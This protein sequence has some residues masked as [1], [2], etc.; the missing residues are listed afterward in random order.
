MSNYFLKKEDYAFKQAIFFGMGLSHLGEVKKQVQWRHRWVHVVLG[1][2]ECL[3]VVG[4]IVSLIELGIISFFKPSVRCRFQQMSDVKKVD[5]VARKMPVSFSCDLSKNHPKVSLPLPQSPSVDVSLNFPSPSIDSLKRE[6]TGFIWPVDLDH[7]GL[8]REEK[9]TIDLYLKAGVRDA[10][11]TIIGNKICFKNGKIVVLNKKIALLNSQNSSGSLRFILYSGKLFCL[12][13]SRKLEPVYDFSLGKYFLKKNIEGPLEKEL[14]VH[15]QENRKKRG[16]STELFFEEEEHVL[17]SLRSQNL[18]QFLN[19]SPSLSLQSKILLFKDLIEEMNW[20]HKKRIQNVSLE[21]GGEII[22]DYFAFHNNIHFEHILIST[23]KGEWRA[24]FC[25]WGEAAAHPLNFVFSPVF[26]SPEYQNFYHTVSEEDFSNQK[27]NE[28]VAFNL[29]HGQ[30]KDFWA[31]GWIFLSIL[32]GKTKKIEGWSSE[33]SK[34][35]DFYI[36]PVDCLSFFENEILSQEF[37]DERLNEI[38][39]GLKK[40]SEEKEKIEGLFQ[41]I[42]SML[43]LLP[44]ERKIPSVNDLEIFE[45]EENRSN[46]SENSPEFLDES[47]P[48]IEQW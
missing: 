11:F 17:E 28:I 14:L 12:N 46:S 21:K 42:S 30:K 15:M 5:S 44:E 6:E 2:T 13:N 38:K 43:K 3:P 1:L 36:P 31:L 47:H 16:L 23:E 40:E 34:A 41:I 4:Q 39:E 18:A 33:E 9:K 24:E 19:S 25:G 8:S 45:K 7:L 35:L 22:E 10:D 27:R 26:T 29:K 20:L 48:G 37:L 32:I